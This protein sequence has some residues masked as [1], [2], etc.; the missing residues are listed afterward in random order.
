MGYYDR[1][2]CIYKITSP[3]NRIYIGQ[4]T[5]YNFRISRYRNL[6]CEKQVRI[7][8]SL[9]KYGFENHVFDIIERCK[10]EELDYRERFWQEFY[11][12]CGP[13]GLNVRY[14]R[15]TDRKGSLPQY[16]KDKI[17]IK[18]SGSGN[19]MYGRSMTESAK[20]LQRIALSGSKNYLSKWILNTETGIYYECLR[21]AGDSIGMDKRILWQNIVKY[22]VNRT[23]FIYA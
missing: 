2:P 16:V 13:K 10:E 9:V 22:R 5:W 20:K 6:L 8:N 19:G 11:E 23:K 14:V 4:T 18:N 7:Y 12:V 15:S 17:S 1:F 3:S 21:E